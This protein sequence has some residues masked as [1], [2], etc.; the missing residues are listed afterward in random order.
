MTKMLELRS[1][2]TTVENKQGKLVGKG[3]VYNAPARI[4]QGASYFMEVV[5][6]NAIRNKDGDIKMYFNHN[7]A[8][9]M[10]RTS[11]GTLRLSFG[12]DGVTYENDIPRYLKEK[13]VEQI[14]RGELRGSSWGA[15]VTKQ[16]WIMRDKV[17]WREIEELELDHISPVYDP[18][19]VQTS[20]DL[21][22][23]PSG[24]SWQEAYS[25]LLKLKI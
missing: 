8:E 19:Y 14:E 17:L 15:T 6:P 18:A 23:I 24:M 12:A 16:N 25:R 13:V 22:S 21:R 5:K 10:G 20:V 7:P 2:Q 11:A 4:P 3:I 9:M 1:F